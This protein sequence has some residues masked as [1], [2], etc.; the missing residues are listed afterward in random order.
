MSL[1]DSLNGWASDEMQI[2]L[3]LLPAAL[4]FG[5]LRQ[6]QRAYRDLVP[7]RQFLAVRTLLTKCMAQC[8]D[9]PR[10]LNRAE[11][12]APHLVAHVRAH[13]HLH[14]CAPPGLQWLRAEGT[15]TR[16]GQ[17]GEVHQLRFPEQFP[18]V[19]LEMCSDRQWWLPCSETL[20]RHQFAARLTGDP[21]CNAYCVLA[22]RLQLPGVDGPPLAQR[23]QLQ[24]T[25]C[26]VWTGHRCDDETG[27]IVRKASFCPAFFKALSEVLAE[28][29]WEQD[30][31]RDGADAFWLLRCLGMKLG[32]EAFESGVEPDIEACDEPDEFVRRA[33]ATQPAE[34]W[35]DEEEGE[36]EE[37]PRFDGRLDKRE[38]DLRKEPWMPVR[39]GSH[40][41][42]HGVL[43]GSANESRLNELAAKPDAEELVVDERLAELLACGVELTHAEPPQGNQDDYKKTAGVRALT[44]HIEAQLRC[45]RARLFAAPIR[46]QISI[47]HPLPQLQMW[48]QD[49][50][51][52][53][54]LREVWGELPSRQPTDVS[55][56]VSVQHEAGTAFFWLHLGYEQSYDYADG[57]LP[58]FIT[59]LS[60][61][62]DDANKRNGHELYRQHAYHDRQGCLQTE[63]VGS[64]SWISSR[65][66]TRT[67]AATTTPV[68]W[69]TR[70]RALAAL[71]FPSDVSSEVLLDAC[72]GTMMLP[73]L[74]RLPH[75][76]KAGDPLEWWA[77]VR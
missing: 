25:W 15:L 77:W 42:L 63:L 26:L 73:F 65:P 47:H 60:V 68:P 69:T 38:L 20:P 66:T 21:S 28:E 51:S 8:A 75:R 39:D 6:V 22:Q 9:A 72:R 70:H 64:S 71:G 74:T 32:S 52:R 58:Q 76:V 45:A 4:H 13:I 40:G 61:N 11:E 7:P 44:I 62:L 33:F 31:T 49:L 1:P 3:K 10:L 59:S 24:P 46:K 17:S 30:H 57:L 27:E 41:V 50:W 36:E 34:S 5:Q 48:M 56:T 14:D 18:G 54:T 2:V 29:A 43:H 53:L 16:V 12:F 37:D 35:E 55:V 23:L 19:T 67:R